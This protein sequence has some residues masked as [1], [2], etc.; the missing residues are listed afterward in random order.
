[1]SSGIIRV[2]KS[3]GCWIDTPADY[4]PEKALFNRHIRWAEKGVW[5]SLFHTF[6]SAG[7]PPVQVLIDSSAV[8]AHRSASGKKAGGGD[9]YSGIGCAVGIPNRMK[10][11]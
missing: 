8:K 10:S 2:L 4:R 5:S 9:D 3:G 6:G 1:M 7:G 11:S